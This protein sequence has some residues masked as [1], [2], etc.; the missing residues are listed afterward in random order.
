M[1]MNHATAA[2]NQFHIQSHLAALLE[3]MRGIY[4]SNKQFAMQERHAGADIS[5]N[6][7]RQQRLEQIRNEI[8]ELQ[9][10]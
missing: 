4:S 8:K 10:Y 2:M 7:A 6:H 1:S 3:E 9:E 5:E